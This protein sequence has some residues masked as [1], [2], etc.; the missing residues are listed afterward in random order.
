MRNVFSVGIICLCLGACNTTNL[1]PAAPVGAATASPA[2]PIGIRH[3][4]HVCAWDALGWD[5]LSDPEKKAFETLGWSSDNW[6][7]GNP[8]S[9]SKDWSELTRNEKNAA[10]ALGYNE[11]NWDV[12][13]PKDIP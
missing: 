7:S 8:A 3:V 1:L 4:A 13:C 11:K 12:T 5:E 6:S 2:Q 10:Q 9:S